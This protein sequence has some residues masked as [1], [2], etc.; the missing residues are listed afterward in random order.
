MTVRSVVIFSAI[1]LSAFPY[2]VSCQKREKAPPFPA[3]K[4]AL[5]TSKYSLVFEDDFSGN[6]DKWNIWTGG[7]YNDELQYY[8]GDNLKLQNGI[9]AINARKENVTGPEVPGSTDPKN[10]DYTSGR[11][12]SKFEFSAAVSTGGIRISASIRLAPGYGMWPAFWTYGDPWPTCGEIDILEA[13]GE[14][15]S[16]TTDYFYGK[17][18]GKVQTNDD[19]TVKTITNSADLTKD[20]HLYEVEWTQ[21][22]L[23][24]YLDGQ[25]VD[26]KLSTDPGGGYIPSF[27][28]KF[29]HVTLNLAVGGRMFGNNFDPSRIETGT[30]YVDWVRIYKIK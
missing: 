16:Y 30:M 11:I 21:H 29:Q 23:T 12:E 8:H 1:T 4:Y 10:F 24:Y 9:L 7:A 5:D 6:L 18:P 27:Y 3:N 25:I 13:T 19:L 26:K 22:S 14:G 20:T 17:K 28:N 15:Q 2:M